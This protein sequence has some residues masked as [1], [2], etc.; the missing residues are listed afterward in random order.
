MFQQFLIS[1]L[2]NWNK[3]IISTQSSLDHLALMRLFSFYH[4]YVFYLYFFNNSHVFWHRFFGINESR[5]FLDKYKFFILTFSTFFIHQLTC[6][7]NFPF[8]ITLKLD[9]KHFNRYAASSNPQT[10]GQSFGKKTGTVLLQHLLNP[11]N[12]ST[13]PPSINH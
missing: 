9:C 5:R 1:I 13:L 4:P 3:P 7:D 11:E 12:T 10:S 2:K 6:F 8:S